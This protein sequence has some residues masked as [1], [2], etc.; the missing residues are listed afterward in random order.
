MKADN[1]S[2]K[3]SVNINTSAL[4]NIDIPVDNEYYS[5]RSNFINQALR[6]A[7]ERQSGTLDRIINAKTGISTDKPWFVGV[8]SLKKSDVD[9]A[10]SRGEKLKITGYGVLIVEDG[11]D[12]EGLFNAVESIK[13]KGRRSALPE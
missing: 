6:E 9:A 13:I 3:V 8:F 1:L 5:N 12:E 4:S 11:I 7:P 2:E 10:L